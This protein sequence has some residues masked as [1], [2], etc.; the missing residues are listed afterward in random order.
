MIMEEG[1]RTGAGERR[2]LIAERVCR[3]N[4]G[5][6]NEAGSSHSQSRARDAQ[7]RQ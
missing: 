5:R 2:S 1:K 7:T 4:L 3:E 6:R